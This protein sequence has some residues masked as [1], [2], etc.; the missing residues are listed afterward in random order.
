MGV[1]SNR[2]HNIVPISKCYIQNKICNDIA[3]DIFEFIKEKDI[4]IYNE[5]TLKGT[6]RHIIVRIGVK[7]NEVL[8][9]IVVND[10]NFKKEKEL[11][12]YI[13]SKYNQVK[14][15][16]KNYN[17]KN[18]NVILGTKNE[19]IFGEGYIYDILGEYKFKISPLSFYQVNPIQTEVLYNTAINYAGKSNKVALD[20]YCGIGTIGIFASKN[21]KKVYG[22][23]KV[24]QAIDDARENAQ[25]NNVENIEFYVGDVEEK[26]PEILKNID[27][28]PTTIFVDPPRKGLDNETI[29][30]LKKLQPEKIV[31][32][33]CNP[34]TLAR[35]LK[36][37]EERY[38][39]K[40]IQPVDMFPYTSHVECCSVLS[41]KNSIQ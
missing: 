31:Y 3:Q 36:E 28:P 12:E 22:I 7:T 20:L 8:V 41:L 16:V 24:A 21:F 18:T 39:I 27:E 6:V 34:A 2:S 9:T 40:E 33:S 11:V 15:I 17:T 23:E 26:L 4:S 32:I 37:L 13:K 30:V 25:I 29:N 38:V 35:D 5:K 10:N 19:I 14:S 1:Y